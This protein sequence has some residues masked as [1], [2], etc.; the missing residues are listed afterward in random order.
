M[1]MPTRREFIKTG[2]ATSA[3]AGLVPDMTRHPKS[4]IRNPKSQEEI[5]KV[6]PK[7]SAGVS[8]ACGRGRPRP[9]QTN[10]AIASVIGDSLLWCVM[11]GV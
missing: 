1:S 9:G 3:I 11:N 8:P 7:G 5:A 10:F 4:A 2:L 6:A